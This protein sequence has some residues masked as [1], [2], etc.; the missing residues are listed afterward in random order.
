VK[1]LNDIAFA[2]SGDKGDTCTVGLI[3]RAPQYYAAL[4]RAV[5]P[6]RIKAL[7]GTWAT[8]QVSVWPMD[9]IEAVLVVIR[10][11]IGGG[12]TA[13]LR[14][15]QTGKSLGYALLRLAVDEDVA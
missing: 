7:L 13:T 14:L 4:Q 11:G 2:R 10:G 5:T 9:N 15:D 12:A 1:L 6:E 8:G 3:A